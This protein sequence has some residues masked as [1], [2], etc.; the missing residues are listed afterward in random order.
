[1]DE[2]AIIREILKDYTLPVRGYHG[3]D[4]W[5]RVRENGLRIAGTVGANEE[6][7]K[8]FALFHD[9][10][11]IYEQRDKGHGHRGA[12]LARKLRWRLFELDDEDFDLLYHACRLHTDGLTDAD[13]TIQACWDADRLDLGRCGITPRPNLLCTD[14]ARKILKWANERSVTGYVPS[15]VDKE[16]LKV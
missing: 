9:S 1:M 7:V 16:W 11:R 5:A 14:A 6:V 3:L 4:H 12:E 2:A 10:R 8:L 15:I 13:P